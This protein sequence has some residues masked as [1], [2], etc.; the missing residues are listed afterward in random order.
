MYIKTTVRDYSYSLSRLKL[1]R[2]TIP[3]VGENVQLLKVSSYIA[4]RNG[5]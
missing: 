4:R 1:R 5:K 3:C 2:L